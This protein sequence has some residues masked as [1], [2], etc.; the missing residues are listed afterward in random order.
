MWPCRILSLLINPTSPFSHSILRSY[1][2]TIY[3][4]YK[5]G[6][7]IDSKFYYIDRFL[8][9]F[10]IIRLS[11]QLPVHLISGT[12]TLFQFFSYLGE[13]YA[14]YIGRALA[15]G[16]CSSKVIR[17]NLFAIT[18]P[19]WNSPWKVLLL[20]FIGFSR[21]LW[22]SYIFRIRDCLN[23][24]KCSLITSLGILEVFGHSWCR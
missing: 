1:D 15:W 9:I 21:F 11:F 13:M 24:T 12:W 17:S 20:E 14:R 5:T 7:A 8:I 18:L 3:I 4:V 23:F 10:R 22:N 19:Y 6:L 16:K 2:C